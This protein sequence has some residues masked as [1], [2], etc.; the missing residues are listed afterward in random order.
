MLDSV[1][2]PTRT[3]HTFRR[4]IRTWELILINT[5]AIIGTGWLFAAN[6]SA[7]LAGPAALLS[8]LIGALAALLI[9]LSY[10][11]LGATIPEAGGVVRYP[12]YTHT[13]L[14]SF[15]A[16]WGAFLGWV[17]L[18][19]LEV[20]G[21]IQYS[22]SYVGGLYSD[23]HLTAV[24]FG[25]AAILL[26][27]F[28]ALNTFGIRLFARINAVV[29][30]WKLLVPMIAVAGLLTAFVHPAN[31][32]AA[33]FAPFGT[34]G[35]LSAVS[36]GGIIFAFTGFRHAVDLGSEAR[37]PG[38]SLPRAI[39]WTLGIVFVLYEL[40]QAAF[41]GAVPPSLLAS[42]WA[43]VSF[44]A[45]L[46]DLA[47][48]A[49]LSWIGLML[50]AD[51]IL[52]PSSVA[53]VNL[54]TTPRSVYA[55]SLNRYFPPRFARLNRYGVPGPALLLCV[56]V[57]IVFLL[58]FPSWDKFV[59]FVSDA[60]VLTYMLGPLSVH[61]LRRTAATV[62]RPFRVPWA[63]L[64]TPLTFIL[65][66]LII[67]WSG[68]P[69]TGYV[70]LLTA[71]GL[72]LYLYDSR[73]YGWAWPQVGGGLWFVGYLVFQAI[74][75]YA[76]TFGPTAHA[77]LPAPWDQVFDAAGSLVF[78]YLGSAAGLPTQE[79]RRIRPHLEGLQDGRTLQTSTGFLSD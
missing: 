41:I 48:L 20:E 67:F 19:P 59:G 47:G 33:G 11:E 70:L 4:E 31:F 60:L 50:Q 8:W 74:A 77:L 37:T 26:V 3:L 42:G 29:T 10:A 6:I 56:A 73:R 40:L 23:H 35:V 17:A 38:R 39:L 46:V 72:L 18:P 5:G 28:A 21:A 65:C 36:T 62:R 16:G 2:V 52:S 78:F 53:Y 25:L 71:S 12:Q 61:V 7:R 66:G 13:N 43:H 45:P 75:S 22:R 15:L 27:G 69:T 54:A 49:G 64:L 68:W 57:G 44:A 58:P 51:S 55:L 32:T 63:R 76:G 34:A 30:L 24:G 1:P 9:G 79:L 14:V